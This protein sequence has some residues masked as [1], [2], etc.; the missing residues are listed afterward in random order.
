MTS[1][2]A[3]PTLVGTLPRERTLQGP[4]LPSHGPRQTRCFERLAAWDPV[5]SRVIELRFFGG[6][7]ID[8][9][10]D[11]M[12]ISTAT[13]NRHWRMAKAWLQGELTRA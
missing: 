11:V 4:R 13:A 1:S 2:D 9:C 7:S 10:A 3:P 6:L 12:Q 8:E 5:K